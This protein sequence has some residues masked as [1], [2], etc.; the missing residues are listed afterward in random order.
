MIARIELRSW[1]CAVLALAGGA[2]LAPLP[3]WA[4]GSGKAPEGGPRVV[5]RAYY[6][7]DSFSH[8]EAALGVDTF[9]TET[10]H[11]KPGGGVDAE[12]LLTPWLGIDLAASQTH[13]EADR[14]TT[15]PVGPAFETRGKIQV[16]PF[17]LGLYGHFYRVEHADIYLGP[18]VGVV[19]TSGS[20]F[21]GTG[22]DLGWGAALGIDL[23][24][25]SSGLAISALGRAIASRFPDQLRN[26]SHFRDN[27]LFG[28]GLSYR[29]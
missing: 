28:G 21:R 23:P 25:G 16:R 1:L 7:F 15:T 3:A 14:L 8:S 4:Q 29:W 6:L 17:M 22:T 2:A 20:G 10:Y 12:Y 18:V 5:V 24:I 11:G 27:Y 13:I 26:V 9:T 19:Q